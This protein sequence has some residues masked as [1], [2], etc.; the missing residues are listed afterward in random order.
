LLCKAILE[1]GKAAKQRG[2]ALRQSYVRVARRASVK[3]R[4]FVRMREHAHGALSPLI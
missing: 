4:G 3:A 2:M 1:L